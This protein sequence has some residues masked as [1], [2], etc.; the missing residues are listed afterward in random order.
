VDDDGEVARSRKV[1]MITI[2]VIVFGTAL[3]LVGWNRA[4]SSPGFCSSCHS[5]QE[6][7]FTASKSVHADV[8]CLSCHTG[9]GLAGSLRYIPSLAREVVAE[10][11]GWNVAE[12]I[13]T[14]ATCETCHEDVHADRAPSTP[15][16]DQALAA[17]EPPQDCAACHGDAA[18]PGEPQQ[19]QEPHPQTYVQTHGSD[20]AERPASCAKC[21]ETR[22]CQACH[23][24]T[25]FPHPE[26]WIER[27]GPV[28]QARGSDACT[29]C[30]PTTF[31]VGCHGTEIPHEPTW[32]GEH[33]RQLQDQSDAPC[34]VC[35][36]PQDCKSCHVRHDIHREQDLY[37]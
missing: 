3:L 31:C 16:G 17:R 14:P 29:L 36:P 4:A 22:F 26:N 18:H 23:F 20:V 32:L 8:P 10:V 12:G 6:A 9:S 30:H 27:H 21:H 1:R 11:T 5:M 7:T 34:A 2:T 13:M 19:P 15:E 24:Q 35:H 37:V 33:W 25:S 28:Q